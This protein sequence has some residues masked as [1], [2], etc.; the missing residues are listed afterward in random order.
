MRR[1]FSAGNLLLSA[2]C[3]GLA[4]QASAE[5]QTE[6]ETVVETTILSEQIEMAPLPVP[7]PAQME[8]AETEA[9]TGAVAFV[10]AGP[11]QSA[12]EV[13]IGTSDARAP[14]AADPMDELRRLVAQQAETQGVP[15]ALANAVVTVESSYDPRARG[16]AGEI[17]LMQIKPET[18]RLLGFRGPDSALFHPVTNVRWGMMYL[19]QAQRRG[20]G[21]ICGTILKYNAGHGATAMN[22]V[23]ER[24]CERV[25]ALLRDTNA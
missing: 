17:G 16:G 4:T 18:A 14:G 24:Y 2:I 13:V 7:K 5:E 22:P 11:E 12:G 21:T 3:L 8:T 25:K 1:G 6:V 23:S 9:G 20:G 10:S 15:A 19:A